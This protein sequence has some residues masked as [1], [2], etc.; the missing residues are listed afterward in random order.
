LVLGACGQAPTPG[1]APPAPDDRFGAPPVESPRDVG[2]FAADPCS[3]PLSG[4]DW[5]ALGFTQAGRE[6]ML[7]TGERS[8]VREGPS[9]ERYVSVTMALA[10]EPLAGAYRA[11]QFALFRPLVID[12]L[13]AVA[14]QSSADDVSCTVS[15]A[16]ANGQGILLNY[17]EYG[18]RPDGRPDDPCGRGIRVAER[19]VAFLPPLPGK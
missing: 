13:P 14:E 1:P 16:T 15:V 9:T 12:G 6:E 4:E 7:T 11:R 10:D 5:Q 18:F 3:G 19:I 2:A 8:C 17:S